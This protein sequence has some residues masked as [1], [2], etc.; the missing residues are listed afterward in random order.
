M[1]A[2]CSEFTYPL[3][4][5]SRWILGALYPQEPYKAKGHILVDCFKHACLTKNAVKINTNFI[6][7]TKTFV[8]YLFI[9]I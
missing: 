1:P 2:S 7:Y 9:L 3:T 6:D 5:F 8:I 4:F